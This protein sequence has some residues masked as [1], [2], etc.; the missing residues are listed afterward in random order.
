MSERC[1]DRT[2]DNRQCQRDTGH[3][4]RHAYDGIT[5][6]TCTCMLRW[7]PNRCEAHPEQNQ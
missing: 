4:Q 1:P 5:G 2:D 3:K 7:Y 6:K